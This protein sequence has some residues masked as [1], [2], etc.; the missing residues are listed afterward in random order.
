MNIDEALRNSGLSKQELEKL[1]EKIN[2][3]EINVLLIGSTGAG[4][5]STI[6]A[7]FSTN[8][9]SEPQA[10]VGKGAEPETMDIKRYPLNNIVIW[11]SPGLGDSE[12]KDQQHQK[13]IVELLQRK[14]KKNN[15]L[16]DLI[17]LVIDGASRDFSST[18]KLIKD[19]VAPNLHVDEKDRLLI[20]INKA[21]KVMHH[22]FWNQVDNQPSEELLKQLNEQ[23]NTVKKRIQQDTGFNPDVIYYVA[24]E[25]HNEEQLQAPYN[26]MKLLSFI[27]E[28]LP[29]KKR[30]AVV[31]DLNENQENFQSNDNKGNYKEKIEK[32]FFESLKEIAA[33]TLKKSADAISDFFREPQVKKFLFDVSFGILK[34]IFK[35]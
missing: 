4:K 15:P 14:D 6:N 1:L 28:K 24:G 29:K 34:N 13:K 18:Y 7:L 12:E 19:V 27:I 26:L 32:S 11:D 20:G 23:V 10:K 22:K 25:R 2:N 30:A 3:T 5:S 8:G 16:I 21:D 35:K 31:N 9:H 33:D 17:F